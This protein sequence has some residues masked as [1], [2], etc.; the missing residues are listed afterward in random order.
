MPYQLIESV[1]PILRCITYSVERYEVLV[2]ALGT[3]Q[4]QNCLLEQLRNEGRFP[5]RVNVHSLQR[6]Q[7]DWF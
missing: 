5:L 1:L 7:R 4:L 6:P 2:E 3:V